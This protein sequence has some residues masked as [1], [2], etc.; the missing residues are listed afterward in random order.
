MLFVHVQNAKVG[1]SIVTVQAVDDDQ[2]LNGVVRYALKQ[3]S[4]G[5]WKTFAID[6]ITG[7]ITLQKELNRR[8]QKLYSVGIVQELTLEYKNV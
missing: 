4:S 8:R 7:I 1:S 6:E 2:G 3:D 5:H